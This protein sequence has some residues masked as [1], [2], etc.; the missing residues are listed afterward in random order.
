MASEHFGYWQEINIRTKYFVNYQ[1]VRWPVAMQNRGHRE[2]SLRIDLLRFSAE[3]QQI[4]WTWS[5]KD[6][7]V[8]DLESQA[9]GKH[10]IYTF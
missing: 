4:N 3:G 6:L 1:N 5:A 2:G 8:R 9:S 10:T 7:Q